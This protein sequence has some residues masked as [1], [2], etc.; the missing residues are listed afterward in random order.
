MR[1]INPAPTGTRR[2]LAAP[3]ELASWHLVQVEAD[4]V[5]NA[6]GKTGDLSGA[7]CRHKLRSE[8]ASAHKRCA[9]VCRSAR[10][11]SA[12]QQRKKKPTE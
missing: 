1:C 10:W 2:N 6:A 4:T 8:Q 12:R 7:G 3:L 11:R 5:T 9:F